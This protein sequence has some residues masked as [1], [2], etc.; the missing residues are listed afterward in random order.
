MHEKHSQRAGQIPE[1]E[2]EITADEVA[3]YIFQI[4]GEL[5]AM[6]DDHGLSRLAASLELARSLAAEALAMVATAS[7][8]NAAPEDAA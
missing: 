6:A 7:Q 3:A 1:P 5:T 2:P 4:A 8:P